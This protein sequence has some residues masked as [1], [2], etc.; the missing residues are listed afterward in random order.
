M[1]EKVLKI[2]EVIKGFHMRIED[3]QLR[4]TSGTPLK[5]RVGIEIKMLTVIANIKKLEE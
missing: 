5:E 1:E 4:N 2:E 3:I